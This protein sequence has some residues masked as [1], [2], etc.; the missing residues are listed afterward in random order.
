MAKSS[1][2]WDRRALKRLSDAEKISDVHIKRIKKIYEQAYRDVSKEIER[3]Y[4]AYSKNTGL[5]VE[6]LK[7]L[8][9]TEFPEVEKR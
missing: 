4:K 8:L 7:E 5:D 3:T 1:N 2:Y 9:L 6:K